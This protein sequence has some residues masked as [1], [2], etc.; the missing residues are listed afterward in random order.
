MAYVI[1]GGVTI[2]LEVTTL[3]KKKL[4]K[5]VKSY[6]PDSPDS[7]DYPLVRLMTNLLQHT[8]DLEYGLDI[9]KNR[10]RYLD[11]EKVLILDKYIFPSMANLTFFFRS[12]SKHHELK[13]IFD[14]DI[15][16]L[17]GINRKDPKKDK[18]GFIFFELVSSIL[19]IE[20]ETHSEDAAN[21]DDF[22]LHYQL[23]RKG[24]NDFRL[25]LNHLLQDIVKNKTVD[26]DLAGVSNAEKRI[27]QDDFNRVRLWTRIIAEGGTQIT[28]NIDEEDIEN[29]IPPRRTIKFGN[30]P[31]REDDDNP[32]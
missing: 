27:V 19:L 1:Y 29:N 10:K 2:L 15:K 6:W 20:E 5:N 26:V 12:I 23:A 3:N 16:D 28:E 4:K 14:N 17:L 7:P 31:L 32:V 9:D 18:F 24:K 13:E 30:I 8:S 21:K 11:K 25:R 22:P